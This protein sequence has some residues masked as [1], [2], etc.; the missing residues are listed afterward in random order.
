MCEHDHVLT[1]GSDA[2]DHAV[3]APPHLVGRL[4]VHDRMGP[5]APPR[6]LFANGGGG[7][8][9]VDAVIP[10][11]QLIDAFAGTS[12]TR[13]A[14]GFHRPLKWA[15][16]RPSFA[17]SGQHVPEETRLRPAGFREGNVGPPGVA[18]AL[19]PF[20]LAVTHESDGRLEIAHNGYF[21]RSNSGDVTAQKR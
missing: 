17:P 4:T 12:K 19:A 20:G 2:L 15:G 1:F 21:R 3:C 11:P 13:E 6:D 18:T 9:L 10:L 5:D 16:E 7:P 14:T 8:S